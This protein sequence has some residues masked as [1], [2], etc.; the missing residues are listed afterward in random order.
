[1]F[2][3]R[4]IRNLF[5]RKK[6]IAIVIFT[7]LVIIVGTIAFYYAEPVLPSGQRNTFFLSFYW[8]METITTVG[9]GDIYPSNTVARFVF[10]AVIIL[11]IG[12]FAM[13]ATE[14]SAYLI[15]TK[16]LEFRGLHHT[17][18]TKHVV[19][20]GYSDA[21]EEL[22]K[23]LNAHGI[24][25]VVIENSVDVSMIRNKGINVISGDPLSTDTLKRAGIENA[26]A[27]V[28]S[29]KPDELAVMASL[30]A[31]E[32]NSKVKVVSTCT[33]FEDYDIMNDARIDSVI[34]LSKIHGG[35]LANA[36]IDSNG[37][38]FL[39]D[40]ITE[41]NG[42]SLEEIS[43]ERDMPFSELQLDPSERPIAIWRRGK[44]TLV[45]DQSTRLAPGDTVIT[46]RYRKSS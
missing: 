8:V 36:V 4:R 26:Y 44:A 10:F 14:I 33:K 13:L 1:M 11:G 40:L 24:D 32:M 38:S 22:I 2:L 41:D 18:L 12:A 3:R 23:Q 21:G 39:L 28:V 37:V 6:A 7:I 19:I 27:F 9:Y 20:V 42:I 16:F 31:K 43:V 29:E 45:F 35:M 15:D 25:A 17:Q 5:S 34:P 46:L 30:K